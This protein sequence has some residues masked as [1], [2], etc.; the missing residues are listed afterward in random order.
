MIEEIAAALDR[1]DY[2]TAAQLLKQLQQSSPDSLWVR[3]FAGRLQEAAGKGQAAATAYRFV[4]QNTTNPKLVSQAREGLQRL[5][6]AQRTANLPTSV[7]QAA[8]TGTG[9]LVLEPIAPEARQSVAQSFA[10]V[11]NL[12]AYTARLILPS[13]GWKLYRVGALGEI[14]GYTQALR[15][16]GMPAFC[17]SL[18]A[19]QKIRVFRVQSFEA[20][21]PQVKVICQNEADELG[22][23]SFHWSEVANR[24]AGSLPIFEDVVDLGAFN[25]LKRKEQTQDFA[26]MMDLHL[27]KRGCILRLCDRSYQFDQGVVF[28]ASQD[29]A[30]SASQTT[31]RIR[32]NKML[33]FL[34]DRLSTVPLWSD[35][36]VFADSAL[37]HLDFVTSLTPYI[38]ILRKAPSNWDSAFHLYSGLVYEYPRRVLQI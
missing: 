29:G 31:T 5:Q 24:V 4:L 6:V 18:E 36:S 15:R 19:V 37:E 25:K 7:A 2:K 23:L 8:N 35:F 3:L 11:M 32:W 12:D 14:Q 1:K 20:A 17:A 30:I 27:P 26:Q 28:D 33:A 21:S 13:R 38:D 22:A 10:Q 16:V 9:F 34:D